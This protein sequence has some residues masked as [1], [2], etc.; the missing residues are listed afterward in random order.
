MT[1]KTI[2]IY[3]FH[4]QY[5]HVTNKQT[6]ENLINFIRMLSNDTSHT[7]L[8]ECTTIYTKSIGSLC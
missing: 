7:I 6:A 1:N 4:S 3:V 8:I 5:Q 2:I